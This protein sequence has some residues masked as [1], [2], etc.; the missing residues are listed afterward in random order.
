MGLRFLMAG[1]DRVLGSGRLRVVGGLGTRR[2]RQ[3]RHEGQ[4]EPDA[5]RGVHSVH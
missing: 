4:R 1:F 3:Q 5:Q 2:D